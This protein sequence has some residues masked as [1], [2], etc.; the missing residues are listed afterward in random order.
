MCNAQGTSGKQR[1]PAPPRLDRSTALFLDVDGTLLEIAARPDLVRVPC[2]LPL[3]LAALAAARDGALALV[4]GRPLA[5]IDQLFPGWRGAA[6]GLHGI[7]QRRADGGLAHIA[8]AAAALAR[9][10]LRGPL[11]KLARERPGLL[12]EDKGGTIAL[13][14]RDMPQA[15]AEIHAL[16]E[17]LCR[18]TKPA[19]RLIAGKKVVEFQPRSISKALAI[20]AFLAE[21]PFRGRRPV[22]LGDDTT[23]EDG[24]VEVNRC[25]GVSIRVG[26]PAATAARYGLASVTEA[27][28]WLGSSTSG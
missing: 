11:A 21:P 6:A 4:S 14:Y 22:F 26:A 3:L 2:R 1:L 16:A 17:A 5:E 7:E 20:A 27:L 9:D 18:A 19:L 8:D 23:D 10:R 12:F 28:E 24:F 25:G 15:E 13:H